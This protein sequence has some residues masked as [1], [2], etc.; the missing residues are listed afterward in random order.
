VELAS[1]LQNAYLRN[2]E[3][4]LVLRIA[5]S[6]DGSRNSRRFSSTFDDFWT[7]TGFLPLLQ[8]E[9]SNGELSLDVT[10][11][12][13]SLLQRTLNPKNGDSVR[14]GYPLTDAPLS[15][16]EKGRPLDLKLSVKPE[17]G[18]LFYAATL[19]YALPVETALP[20]DE[21]IE[22]FSQVE[23]LDGRILD[24][25]ALPPGETLR[26]RVTL[27]TLSRRSFLK[28]IVPV[29]SGAEIVDPSFA[30]TGSYGD[31][32]GTD[33]E[34]WIRETVYGDT[35][36]FD[37]EGYVSFGPDAWEYWFYRP[38]QT[39]YDNAV[40][41]TWEDFYSGQREVSFL[42]RTTTPG[43]YPTP[44]V[45]ASLEFEPEVFGRGSGRLAVIQGD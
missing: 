4:D 19:S 44:P 27:S 14:E 20:R 11:D 21:G 23:T 28:L 1:L 43:I 16:F 35:A 31:R 25:S 39:V 34:S 37:A 8:A 2:E 42:I 10:L 38:L 12:G 9:S 41:Y 18:R 5:L 6:L 33:S 29:P 7:V 30:T 3:P 15:E 45:S 26:M 40:S 17:A 22:V 36:E 24:E 32:G 13:K